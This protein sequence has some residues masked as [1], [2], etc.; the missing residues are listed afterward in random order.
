MNTETPAEKNFFVRMMHNAGK[1]IS[2][3]TRRFIDFLFAKIELG[4]NWFFAC[5]P[6]RYIRER[7]SPGETAKNRVWVLIITSMILANYIMICYIADRNP[8]DIFPS[9]P[10]LDMRSKIT[11]YLP[12]TDAKTVLKETRYLAIPD[13]KEQYIV[14]L[15]K[16][17][18]QGSQFENTTLAVPIES[19]VRKV[20]IHNDVCV[21]DMELVTLAQGITPISGSE[22]LFHD[23]LEKTITQNIPSLKKVYILERGVP[24]KN[25]WEVAAA[26]QAPVKEATA[27]Q[28]PQP[29]VQ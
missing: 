25:L 23:A 12:D 27:P 5:K 16:F 13:N 24:F 9:L 28:T 26:E 19:R 15:V 21:I 29:Q 8:L 11:V 4:E 1:H 10:E 18:V 3:G 22:K 17:V 6:I 14:H 20:W 7:M 2:N